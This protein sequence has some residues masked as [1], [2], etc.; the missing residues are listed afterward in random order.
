MYSNYELN[1]DLIN[2]CNRN[3]EASVVPALFLDASNL[4]DVIDTS[5][6]LLT[7][8]FSSLAQFYNP[9]VFSA[10]MVLQMLM[11]VPMM[12]VN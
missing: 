1:F 3:T 8:I 11:V 7:P 2:K 12:V 6:L 5:L 10:T 9:R 4:L